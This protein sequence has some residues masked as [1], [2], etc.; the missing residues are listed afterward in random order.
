[1]R[2]EDLLSGNSPRLREIAR[3]ISQLHPDII[4]LNEIDYD[5]PTDSTGS[6]GV[7]G[8]RFAQHYLA[9]ADS[10]SIR[11]RAFMAPTNTGLA[12]GFDLDHNG[13]IVS[14]PPVPHPASNGDPAG[15]A[16]GGD[17]WGF[18]MYPGQYAFTI[19]IS[20]RFTIDKAAVRTFQHFRW[21]Q[22]P[23]PMK[24]HDP[25]SGDAWYAPD[26]WAEFPLSSK[27]HVDVPILLDGSTV[28][29]VLAS[30][31]TPPAFDGPEGRNRR[32]NHDEIRFWSYYLGDS[33]FIVD[34]QGRH[35]GLAPSERFVI[36]GDLNADPDE[37]GSLD[38]PIGSYLLAD[39]RVNAE[40]VPTGSVA[41]DDLDPDDTARWGLRVDY[42][43]PSTGTTV[44]DGGI[45]RSTTDPSNPPS[46]HFPVWLD[47]EVP[48]GA[49]K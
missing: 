45:L 4:L 38:N 10:G 15:R 25:E 31:P 41:I 17:A 28:L 48:I 5:Q 40:F 21:S 37:G 24:P 3:L 9:S 1:V 13:E 42:V 2:T 8:R 33:S 49:A 32:R 20:D 27:T 11:Y 30:H 14:T 19:L 16:Y 46:D 18:G 7:N 36:V 35:G 26:V 39:P 29:H 47:V 44:I 34:D 23:E 22:L 43:L 6:G 12:S